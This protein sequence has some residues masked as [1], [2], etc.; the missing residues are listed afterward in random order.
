MR[1]FCAFPS[2]MDSECKRGLLRR[3][4]QQHACANLDGYVS[5]V[6]R[7]KSFSNLWGITLFGDHQVCVADCSQ[8]CIWKVD[9]TSQAVSAYAGIPGESGHHDGSSNSTRFAR[10]LGIASSGS[11]LFVT[12]HGNHCIRK[13]INDMD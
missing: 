4:H 13:V 6:S 11:S 8:H 3:T 5:T 10:P 9:L 7:H 12:D 1:I 2:Q